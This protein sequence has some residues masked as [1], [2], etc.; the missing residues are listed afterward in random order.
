LVAAVA[1]GGVGSLEGGA[2]AAALEEKLVAA[3]AV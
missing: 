1:V 2:V 3:M